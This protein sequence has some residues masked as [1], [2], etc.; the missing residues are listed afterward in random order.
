MFRRRPVECSLIITCER[1]FVCA[2]EEEGRGREE[3]GRRLRYFPLRFLM[4][5]RCWFVASSSSSSSA[6]SAVVSRR[7]R[8]RRSSSSSVPYYCFT[9]S[10]YFAAF[11]RRRRI[12][13]LPLSRSP[14]AGENHCCPSLPSSLDLEIYVGC[15]MEESS[16]RSV[17]ASL[18]EQA[19]G[20]CLLNLALR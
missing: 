12:P 2:T 4:L 20:G 15:R 5:L 11:W 6:R 7:R 3:G 8:H 10:G 17:L 18:S 14:I 13:P 9:A 16:E 19:G 1:A